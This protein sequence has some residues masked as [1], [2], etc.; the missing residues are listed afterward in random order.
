MKNTDFE[1]RTAELTAS[2]EKLV[3]YV[4]RWNS[5]SELIWGEFY[6]MFA[7]YAFKDSLA[8]GR[9][10]RALYEHDYKGLLGRTTSGTLLL[11]EDDTGLRFELDPP[12]TQTGRDLLAL[13]KRGDLSGMSFGFRATKEIWDFNQNPCTRAVTAAELLEITVTATPAYS[14]SDVAIALRSLE[15]ARHPAQNSNARFWADLAGL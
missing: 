4:V 7:P 3:G 9:D 14:E 11:S 6:E 15:R 10:V 13:V 5:R 1:I 2:N 12:D 8:S